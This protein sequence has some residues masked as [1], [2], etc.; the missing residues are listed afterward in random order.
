DTASSAWDAMLNIGR[1]DTVGEQISKLEQRLKNADDLRNLA[2]SRGQNVPAESPDLAAARAQLEALRETERLSRRAADTQAARAAQNQ[3]DIEAERKAETERKQLDEERRRAAE[4]TASKFA[5][6]R[7]GYEDQILK[8]RE[9]SE[10]EKLLAEIQLGRYREFTKAQ[11]EQL[12]ADARRADAAIQAKEAADEARKE[13]EKAS[14]ESQRQAETEARQLDTAKQK[15]LDL[16]NP[17]NKFQRQLEEIGK[18]RDKGLLTPAQALDAEFKVMENMGDELER[19]KNKGKDTFKE[20]K[21][22]VEGWGR[23]ATDTFIEFAFEGKASFGKLV[24][25]ILKDLARMMIQKNV[26][27]PLFSS[28]QGFNWAS[29]F[30]FANGGIMSD[31]G[32]VP[33]RA[34]SAGGIANKPQLALYGEGSMNEAYVPLPDG[35]TIPV[36]LKGAGGGDTYN[37]SIPVTVQ[38]GGDN[39]GGNAQGEGAALGKMLAAAVRS[40]LINQKR[41][42]G[43]LAA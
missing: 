11:Q 18:L 33:L 24:N 5:S 9:L 7:A 15:W 6:I 14:R 37:I 30:G 10:E 28:I 1:E 32:P 26:T 23:Q 39:G 13:S 27:A 41:P 12:L 22:A 34:Y 17:V 16:I 36:T 43:L 21:D 3:R 40:E 20:L 35:R 29:M 31:S 4:A 25:S 19:L 8:T 38:S 42:G 2:R